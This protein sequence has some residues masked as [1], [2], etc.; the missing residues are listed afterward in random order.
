MALCMPAKRFA[1]P[2]GGDPGSARVPRSS[3]AVCGAGMRNSGESHSVM[4]ARAASSLADPRPWRRSA[5]VTL[6]A[7]LVAHAALIVWTVARLFPENPYNPVDVI[8]LRQV[9]IPAALLFAA[10]AFAE[11]RRP[12]CGVAL[13][14]LIV[15]TALF[16]P[17]TVMT[18]ALLL[19]DAWLIGDMLLRGLQRTAPSASRPDA[20]LA[21]LTGLALFIG[22]ISICGQFKVHYT[23]VY[24]VLLVVPMLAALRMLPQYFVRIG[25]LRREPASTS[26]AERIWLAMLGTVVVMHLFA[27]A[28]PE[29]G[30]DAHT[31]HLQFARLVAAWHAWPYEV[32]RY[33]WAVMPLGADWMFAGAY[34]IGGESSVRL[35]NVVFGI[36]T[37]IL[38][39][40][41]VRLYAPRLPALV[42]VALFAS[43]PLAFL[44]T[45]LLFSETL[46]CAFVLGTLTAA[47][48]WLKTRSSAALCALYLLAAGAL[49]TKA[50]S[51]LWLIPLA[52]ALVV[53]SRGAVLALRGSR[54]RAAVAG[55][56]LIGVWPYTNAWWR[57]GNPVF[58]FMNGVFRSPLYDTARSFDNVAYKQ[59]LLPWTPYE[60]VVDSGRF[61]EGAPGAPGFHWLLLLPL[62]AVAFAWR[63]HNRVQW[64]CVA[65]GI[66]FFV[67]VYLQQAYLRYLL[68]TLLVAAAAAG[69]ALADL[70]DGRKVRVVT[71]VL[72]ALLIA[73]NLRF[74][75]TASWTH[76]QLCPRCAFDAEART[77]LITRYAPLSLVSEWLNA[78]I[79]NARVGFFTMQDPSPA[80][81][82]GYSRSVHWHDAAVYE[83]FLHARNADAI[84]EI[85]RAWQLTHVVVHVVA[86]P[87]ERAITD[88]RDRY[89]EPVWEFEN[90]RVARIVSAP[91]A[92]SSGGAEP[93]P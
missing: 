3:I 57:T 30:F 19:I 51:I 56:L 91:A 78:H 48:E 72:G 35:L 16:L 79:P 86:A 64:A 71:A 77:R 22:L 14:T 27:A 25:A 46:W 67:A 36:I 81:Y 37:G 11:R 54:L 55:A 93:R 62:I 69:W 23:P 15:A 60:L 6:V 88:F 73:L 76:A 75:Y 61:L 84:L 4:N 43:A 2:T 68:P 70:P 87:Y 8:K 39:Y 41:L 53:A 1:A 38:L 80:G 58:P 89:T 32:Q 47:L 9:A 65:L 50:I 24:A 83:A 49:Q 33:A 82:T 74:M 44:V 7:L 52:L 21:T 17:G 13:A 92:A 29:V 10:V 85:T 45:G 40:R 34:L 63:R 5:V 42:S 28:K 18:V 20:G 12:A 31:M 90:Y 26:V 66:V 59:A